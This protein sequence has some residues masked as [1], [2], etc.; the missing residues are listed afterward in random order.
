[1]HVV[2][3]RTLNFGEQRVEAHVTQEFLTELRGFYGLGER[4]RV[5]DEH[6]IEYLS[7]ALEHAALEK[8]SGHGSS[9]E[10]ETIDWTSETPGN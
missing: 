2:E 7:R 5:A 3:I 9:V 4:D 10:I 6:M 1:M 8:V